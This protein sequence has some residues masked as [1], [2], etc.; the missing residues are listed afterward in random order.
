MHHFVLVIKLNSL[1]TIGV[2]INTVIWILLIPELYALESLL[3][4]KYWYFDTLVISG[5]LYH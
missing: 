5:N 2:R 1:S 4:S 3:K